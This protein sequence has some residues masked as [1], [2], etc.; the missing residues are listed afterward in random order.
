MSLFFNG[1]L[2]RCLR[3]TRVE[4]HWDGEGR[5]GEDMVEQLCVSRIF[6]SRK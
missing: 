1:R 5:R 4:S 3:A 6:F 2:A